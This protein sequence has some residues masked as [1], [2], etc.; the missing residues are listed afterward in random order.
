MMGDPVSKAKGSNAAGV[1]VNFLGFLSGP[2]RIPPVL[3]S[4]ASHGIINIFSTLSSLLSASRSTTLFASPCHSLPFC[5]PPSLSH[6]LFASLVSEE[7]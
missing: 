4:V 1:S 6:S 5:L 7:S 3:A 2:L